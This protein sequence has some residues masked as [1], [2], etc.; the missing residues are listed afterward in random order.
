MG[1]NV[2]TG[3]CTASYVHLWKAKANQ[4][5]DLK[6]SV[7]LLIDK[8]Q[9]GDI[10]AYEKAIKAAFKQGQEMY[11]WP[12]ALWDSPK[13]KKPLRDGDAEILTGDKKAG[14]GYEG[15]MFLNAN[16][17]G[18]PEHEYYSPPEITKPFNGDVVPIKDQSEFYSGVK[19]LAA[20]SFYAYNNK[21]K[22]IAVGIN[23][24]FKISDGERLDGRESA[25]SAFSDYAKSQENLPSDTAQQTGSSSSQPFE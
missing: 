22:G 20:I 25:K 5:G 11:G 15:M 2:K 12:A 6:F 14:I 7:C 24:V 21:S 3:P 17:I 1:I 23:S 18:D 16:A 4:D 8:K 9:T 13:F 19:T 10:A